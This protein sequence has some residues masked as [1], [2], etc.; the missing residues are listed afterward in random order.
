MSYKKNKYIMKNKQLE[1]DED[2]SCVSFFSCYFFI[3]SNWNL[4]VCYIILTSFIKINNID[5]QTIN[6][7]LRI[8]FNDLV[9]NP[10]KLW[11]AY[12]NIQAGQN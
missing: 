4:Q 8:T 12:K 3:L 11:K 1:K 5:L 10:I 6:V 2:I 7:S 9:K